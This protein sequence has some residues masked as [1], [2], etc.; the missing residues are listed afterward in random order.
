[1]R[2]SNEYKA[3]LIKINNQKANYAQKIV[4][5]LQ[6]RTGAL[7]MDHI[8]TNEQR[9]ELTAKGWTREDF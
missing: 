7:Y 8:F 6:N 9:A 5:S 3:L 4:N 2:C 1:M